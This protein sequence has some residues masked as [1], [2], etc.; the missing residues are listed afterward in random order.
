[1]LEETIH[2]DCETYLV[3]PTVQAPKPV[4]L[5]YCYQPAPSFVRDEGGEG[6]IVDDPA[7]PWRG[8][9]SFDVLGPVPD[10][11]ATEN[12]DPA[13][14]ARKRVEW[15]ERTRPVLLTG[16]DM[17]EFFQELLSSG[18]ISRGV[19]LSFDYLCL[20]TE[21]KRRGLDLYRPFFEYLAAGRYR[22]TEV[23]EKLLAIAR[24]IPVFKTGLEAL[25]YR[26]CGL[27]LSAD[28]TGADAWR[29]RYSEL[30]GLPVE[31]FPY[32]ARR[33]ALDDV[34]HER[35]VSRRQLDLACRLFGKPAIPDQVARPVAR[36][37][38][39][40]QS[41][42]GVLTDYPRAM[43]AR[44]S[45]TDASDRLMSVL[46]KAGLVRSKVIFTGSDALSDGAPITVAGNPAIFRGSCRKDGTPQAKQV[47]FARVEY[48]NGGE[49]IVARKAI[50]AEQSVKHTKNTTEIRDRIK[51]TLAGAGYDIPLTDT[52][53]VK[54]DRET[55]E[56]IAELSDDPGLLC[57]TAKN[58]VDKLNS[59]YI[60]ALCT[61]H[62]M[63]WRYNELVDTGRTSAASQRFRM[64]TDE[65]VGI[66]IKE[67]TNI[68][69]FPGGQALERTAQALF[70]YLP[71][72]ITSQPNAIQTWA[73]AHDPRAMVVARPG[74]IF[75]VFDY[76]AIELGCMARVLNVMFKR[77]S[78]LAKVINT[79]GMDPHLYTG[80]A[81]HEVLWG[82]RL[83]YDELAALY[84]E[85]KAMDAEGV[86]LPLRFEH[87]LQTRK[88]SKIVGFGFLG[89]MGAKKF[90]IYAKSSYGVDVPLRQA[91]ALRQGF[92][93]T[94][95]EIPIYFKANS[96]RLAEGLPV[97]QIGTKRVRRGCT[98]ASAN[99]S[100]FQG[101]A[102]DGAM[103][104]LWLLTWAC[105]AESSS[106]LFG[107]FPLIFEHDA[108][109]L[110]VPEGPRAKPAH[111]EHG[112][113]MIDG[114]NVYLEDQRRPELSVAV[115]VEGDLIERVAPDPHSR[116][117]K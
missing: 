83:T 6:V 8:M 116:W 67:G 16:D 94:Y 5:Q 47:Q 104:A 44:E 28:K 82:E 61:R 54:T 53:L 35:E 50:E 103:Q 45:L 85:A 91:K 108:F 51:A 24:G 19:N 87:V 33:Y 14:D 57:L 117:T 75:S 59:T 73:A 106:P 25:A 96:D 12:D 86:A 64:T 93:R 72:S 81:V 22:D 42:R 88:M 36:F 55:L 74:Y 21:A 95:P 60:E 32:H 31:R 4:C 71:E 110:E 99:N 62:P 97:I 20:L 17:L 41:T 18:F 23:D 2:F 30:D 114:M 52:G 7:L 77:P 66:K 109:I 38:L 105:Y 26:Y 113:L 40:L 39:Y 27:D 102:A 79:P 101:L 37:C 115:K 10:E 29:L 3:S 98:Y 1:M 70:P 63:H 43:K 15:P 100:Y 46:V 48:P 13:E 89:G 68:Q 80:V 76:T 90:R 78:S 84:K 92:L 34:L 9:T 107:S 69:N 58:K 112:K 56:I 65:G 11:E 49:E 111:A